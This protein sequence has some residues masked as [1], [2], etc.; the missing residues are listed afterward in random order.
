[1][2]SDIQRYN[3]G[4][5]RNFEPSLGGRDNRIRTRK[6]F[7]LAEASSA[8]WS[9]DSSDVVPISNGKREVVFG[10]RSELPRLRQPT[11]L[12]FLRPSI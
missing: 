1:L 7:R 4:T 8:F 6:G 11:D 12:G 3:K 5:I 2:A 9:H 10:C